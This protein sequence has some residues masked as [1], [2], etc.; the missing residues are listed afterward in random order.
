VPLVGIVYDQKV[1]SFLSYIGQDLFSDLNVLTADGLRAHIDAACARMGDSA[2][3]AAGVARL[4]QAE[5]Y[6]SKTAAKLLELN[7]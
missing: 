1:S 3:L 4:R 7:V 5:G 2:F 6:N